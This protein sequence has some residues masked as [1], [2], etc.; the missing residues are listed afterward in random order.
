MTQPRYLLL[1]LVTLF[2]AALLWG[3]ALPQLL[4]ARDANWIG[5]LYA[6][7]QARAG[8]ENGAKVV[9]VSGS[10]G[11]FGLDSEAMENRLGLPVVNFSTHA[12]LGIK[13]LLHRGRGALR[14]GD[15]ALM[16][17]EYELLG[18][19]QTPGRILTTFVSAK[20]L[21][22]MAAAPLEWVPFFF[23]G[24]DYKSLVWALVERLGL[25]R[26]KQTCYGSAATLNSYG[27][28]TCAMTDSFTTG[29]PGLL[30]AQGAIASETVD[31]PAFDPAIA[32]F[33]AWAKNTGVKVVIGFPPLFEKTVYADAAHKKAFADLA[34]RF[35]DFG[36]PV[37]GR[38][39][40]FLYPADHMYD[41]RYHLHSKAREIHTRR[42]L[43]LLCDKAM[44]CKG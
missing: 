9:L 1:S 16:A 21:S 39:T 10:S 14:A 26:Y 32:D 2:A 42:M 37:L 35:A 30:L 43:E 38:P 7:K 44:T 17:L 29:N 18:P 6:L 33:L 23:T 22:Y 19:Q 13:Y 20:D 3:I 34:E 12:G 31:P 24:H 8:A 40:D 15:T 5:G 11:L 25:W 36:V 27:D 28:E 4:P 41:T